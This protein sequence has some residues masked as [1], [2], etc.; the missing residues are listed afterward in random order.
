MQNMSIH[1][2]NRTE[3][4]VAAE[5]VSHLCCTC[6]VNPREA[7]VLQIFTPARLAPWQCWLCVKECVAFVI[8]GQIEQ[9]AIKIAAKSFQC[10]HDSRQFLL[11]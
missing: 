1:C 11:Q 9:N 8:S 2:S 6:S 10:F 4:R 5:R 3:G 7:E